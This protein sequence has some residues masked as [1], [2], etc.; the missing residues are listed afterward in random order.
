MP[1]RWD[2][3]KTELESKVKS[4]EA[5][6]RRFLISS[7]FATS[8]ALEKTI[9]TPDLAEAKF[10]VLFD[11]EGE[12]VVAYRDGNRKE[13]LYSRA[14]PSKLAD[15]DEALS[16]LVS[17]D[18]NYSKWKAGTGASGGGAPGGAAQGSQNV[19]ERKQFEGMDPNAQMKFV[20]EGGTVAEAA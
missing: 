16:I 9:L 13:K 19:I 5:N 15:F 17:S 8:K 2:A 4:A 14:D 10:G 6:V 18:P 3:E 7:R 12:N 11:V 1:A 20:R